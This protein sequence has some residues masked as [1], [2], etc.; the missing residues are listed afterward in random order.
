MTLTGYP[1]DVQADRPEA[2]RARR[3]LRRASRLRLRGHQRPLLPVAEGPSSAGMGHLPDCATRCSRRL[4]RSSGRCG[5]GRILH[6]VVVAEDEVGRPGRPEG[7]QSSSPGL[8][9][10]A[11]DHMSCPV[12]GAAYHV[13]PRGLSAAAEV[14]LHPALGLAPRARSPDGDRAA[15]PAMLFE[16]VRVVLPGGSR[17]A[18]LY[19]ARGRLVG[20][21]LLAGA[22]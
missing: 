2:A 9:A 18:R 5:R 14:E 1:D 15:G 22:R 3:R 20:R 4:S 16:V 7:A 21:R 11:H 8:A 10:L 12:V 6:D 17:H 13:P 19:G